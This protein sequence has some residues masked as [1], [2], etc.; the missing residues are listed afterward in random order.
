[1]TIITPEGKCP[2]SLGLYQLTTLKPECAIAA[3][4]NPPINVCEDEDGMPFHQVIKFQIIAA[5]IPDKI[6]TKSIFSV[7]AV[8]ATVSA[9]PKP[10]TQKAKKLKKAA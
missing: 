6:T 10:K 8:L 9:T 2:S 4:A 3:P 1:M 5:I 7:L